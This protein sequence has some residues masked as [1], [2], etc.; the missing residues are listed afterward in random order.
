[1]QYE[2]LQLKDKDHKSH[3]NYPHCK[4]VLYIL[5]LFQLDIIFIFLQT[6]ATLVLKKPSPHSRI[7]QRISLKLPSL[8]LKGSHRSLLILSLF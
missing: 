8:G 7:F 1:M 3:S 2:F 5:K 6:S 4:A